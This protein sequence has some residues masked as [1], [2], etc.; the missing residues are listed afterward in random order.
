M[1]HEAQMNLFEERASVKNR[2]YWKLFIDGASRNNPGPSGI[3][4]FLLKN[5]Q[6]FV[7]EG[8]FIGVKTNNQAEYLALVVG[9]FF[10]QKY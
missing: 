4:I 6:P 1:S 7:S 10:V 2:S 9:L 3:G 8:F 5:D